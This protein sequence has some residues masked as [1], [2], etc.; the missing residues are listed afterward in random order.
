MDKPPY[1]KPLSRKPL[2][3]NVLIY[4]GPSMKPT[5]QTYDIIQFSPS[6]AANI[7]IGDIVALHF[8]DNPEKKIIH[9]VIS[10]R[11]DRVRT[12]GDN[13]AMPDPWIDRDQIL[14]RV[15]RISRNG[16]EYPVNRGPH[17]FMSVIYFRTRNWAFSEASLILKY[18]YERIAS[19]HILSKYTTKFFLHSVRQIRPNFPRELHIQV[20]H[21]VIAHYREG[22]PG[23]K[24]RPPFRI[25]IDESKMPNFMSDS[26]E[27]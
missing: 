14:G 24:I 12:Q 21:V 10:I 17:Q 26:G 2:S 7:R 8:S 18:P 19:S 3:T 25:L 9:R 4:F 15:T 5:L 1:S 13:C 11:K 16:I 27:S 23:W 20:G 6:E 22:M